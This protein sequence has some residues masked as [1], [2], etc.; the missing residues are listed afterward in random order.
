MFLQGCT[1]LNGI[2]LS[3]G[4]SLLKHPAVTLGTG[5]EGGKGGWM[6]QG[7]TRAQGLGLLQREHEDLINMSK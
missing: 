1:L 3:L 6:G 4:L 7:K 2:F 5:R